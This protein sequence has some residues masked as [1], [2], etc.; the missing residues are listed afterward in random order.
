MNEDWLKFLQHEGKSPEQTAEGL[1]FG[2]RCVTV[3]NGIP[4]FVGDADYCADS[5]G[6]LRQRH[7]TLQLDSVNGTSDRYRTILERTGWDPS[8]FKN[9]TV[10][11]CG[12][13]AGPD[14]EILLRLGA[15]VL[16]ADL[17]E[18]DV[19]KDNVQQQGQVG[20]IQADIANLPL[21]PGSFDIVFCHRVL[22]HTP[23]PPKTLAHILQFVKPGGAVFVHS[24][25]RSIWQMMRW[26][27]LLRPITKRMEGEKVYNM[28]CGYGPL[29]FR[30]TNGLAKIP[31][32]KLLDYVFVPF[33]NKRSLEKFADLSD[34]EIYWYSVHD[35]FDAL[36][37][38]YDQPISA[39]LMNQIAKQYLD[40]PFE[41]ERRKTVTLL[42]SIPDS[43]P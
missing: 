15:K 24:Y 39:K 6:K 8:F 43:E 5:F 13:G 38:A 37:P 29:A 16:A 17:A 32:G 14:T 12:C 7:A 34:E 21:K 33:L 1:R 20:F 9:K 10:L 3:T 11:E 35:T 30:L 22:Q 41:I 26:K 18:V 36:S 40:R 23:D 2:D 4:R 25:A 19:A 28:V 27:Y 31:G 42:R